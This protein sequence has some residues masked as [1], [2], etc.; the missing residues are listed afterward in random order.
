MKWVLSTFKKSKLNLNHIFSSSELYWDHSSTG[1]LVSKILLISANKIVRALC[2]VAFGK[3]LMYATNKYGPKIEPCGTPN[4]VLIH[5]EN[6][7]QFK[8]EFIM[9]TLVTYS[10]DKILAVIKLNRINATVC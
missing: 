10:E 3:S 2:S 5:F 6:V 7:I 4:F 1:G 9:W 8:Y